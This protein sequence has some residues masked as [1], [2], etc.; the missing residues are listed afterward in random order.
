VITV[1][2]TVISTMIFTVT[3]CRATVKLTANSCNPCLNPC[4]NP[5]DHQATQAAQHTLQRLATHTYTLVS[6][7]IY[8]WITHA[9]PSTSMPQHPSKTAAPHAHLANRPNLQTALSDSAAAQ[10]HPPP[11]D[12]NA[13]NPQ[14]QAAAMRGRAGGGVSKRKAYKAADN[15]RSGDLHAQARGLYTAEHNVM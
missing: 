6:T 15:Q 10:A 5:P 4:L 8:P 12:I 9:E 7:T 11:A 13:H 1:N 3:F 14:Y 2:F